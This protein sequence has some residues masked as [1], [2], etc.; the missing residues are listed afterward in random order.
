[1]SFVMQEVAQVM[2]GVEVFIALI[3]NYFHFS[4]FMSRDFYHCLLSENL[5]DRCKVV[6]ARLVHVEGSKAERRGR[7]NA[8]P[9]TPEDLMK[10]HGLGQ[11]NS[12]AHYMSNSPYPQVYLL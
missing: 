10:M 1:M 6:I 2:Q 12:K 9:M 11:E 4:N 3:P 7:R 8:K 5:M